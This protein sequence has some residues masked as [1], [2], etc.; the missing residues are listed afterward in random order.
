[1]EVNPNI[2]HRICL[3]TCEMTDFFN[4]FDE[5]CVYVCSVMSDKNAALQ[6]FLERN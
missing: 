6:M 5:I 3:C 2:F 4:T 1:M